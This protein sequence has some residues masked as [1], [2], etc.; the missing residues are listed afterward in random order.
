MIEGLD[1]SVV[2][3]VRYSVKGSSGT[4]AEICVG[5][6]NVRVNF[7]RAPPKAKIAKGIE[8]SG[9]SKSWRGGGL[10]VTEENVQKVGTLLVAGAGAKPAPAKS[11]ATTAPAKSTQANA[12]A[13][14]SGRA[15]RFRAF[16]PS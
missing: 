6:R 2:P 1:C 5:K 8:L 4:V 12:S 13:T 14:T 10:V 11:K 3:T 9:H 15:W 16:S 7:K